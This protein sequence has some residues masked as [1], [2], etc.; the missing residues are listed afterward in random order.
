MFA[1]KSR[2]IRFCLSL[3]LLTIMTLSGS[4]LAFADGPVVTATITG[5]GSLSESTVATQAPSA[6]LTGSNQT[7]TYTMPITLTDLTGTGAGWNLTITST[8]FTTTTPIHTLATTAS[9]ITGVTSVHSG[10]GAYTDPTNNITY[11]PLA[12]PAAATAPAAVKLF[13]A[14]A[15]TGMGTFT[16]TPTVAITIPANTYA[17]SYTSTVTLAVASGP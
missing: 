5:G 15:N 17:G 1:T 4:A 11:G 7:I 6:T 10:A 12:V 9:S 14:T 2:A 16:V 13:N 3:A 8:Q